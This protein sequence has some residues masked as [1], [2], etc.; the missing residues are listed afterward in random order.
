MNIHNIRLR[1]FL[2]ILCLILV[3]GSLTFFCG[4]MKSSYVSATEVDEIG[5]SE[6][7][8]EDPGNF[9][10]NITS[11]SGSTSL[12]STLRILLVLTVLTIAPSIILMVTSFTRIIIVLN[13]SRTALGLQ[14]TPPNQVLI[15]LALF[16]TFFIMSPTISAINTN[17][18]QPFEAGQITQE[19]ALEKGVEPIREFMFSQTNRKDIKLF[20]DISN[21]TEAIE[22]YK[23]IPTSTLIPA[24][25]ISELRKAMI[26][27]FLIYLPFIVIDMIV[28]STLMSM[29]MMM[30]PP[31]TISM[32]FKIL[33]FVLADGWNL[34][35][36]QLVR[37]FY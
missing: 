32:P 37:T 8:P 25:M 17:A 23:E 7:V 27:G 34:V 12:S 10:L 15:G 24:F 5:Q 33:L 21:N 11:N 6:M 28:A 20:L 16:L 3:I 19:E 35:I 22:D 31:T 26:M 14:N 9:N 13:F 36:G 18:I 1:K 4:I 30:L 2:H 29:G